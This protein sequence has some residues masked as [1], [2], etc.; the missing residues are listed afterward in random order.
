M[1]ETTGETIMLAWLK[2]KLNEAFSNREIQLQLHNFMLKNF[3]DNNHIPDCWSRYFR[4]VRSK[5]L[6]EREGLYISPVTDE[7]K[8][9]GLKTWEIKSVCV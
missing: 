1:K 6:L 7:R 3:P 8:F 9:K 4:F 5:K 2:D